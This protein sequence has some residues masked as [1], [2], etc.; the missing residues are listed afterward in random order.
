M[1]EKPRAEFFGR[2]IQLADI[3]LNEGVPG[4]E[5][6]AHELVEGLVRAGADAVKAHVGFEDT[7]EAVAV[8]GHVEPYG[9]DDAEPADV[10]DHVGV[11]VH[12]HRLLYSTIGSMT[13]MS[14]CSAT[15]SPSSHP[16]MMPFWRM[17]FSYALM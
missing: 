13:L 5:D 17:I 6:L 15:A 16:P 7:A 1:G 14:V 10:S 12:R 4:E 11:V 9:A 2:V 3:I 8:D